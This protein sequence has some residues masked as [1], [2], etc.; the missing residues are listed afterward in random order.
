MKKIII[1]TTLLCI[2][3][4]SCT[5]NDAKRFI[6]K[7]NCNKIVTDNN[8]IDINSFSSNLNTDWKITA[9]FKDDG[10]YIIDSIVNGKSGKDYPQ[11]GSYSVVDES[12]IM[13]EEEAT[14]IILNNTMI[15][16]F[17]SGKV[18]HY[19]KKVE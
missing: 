4:C 6:G 2:V 15:I 13:L 5:N 12:N 8:E 19:Y 10:T 18:K 7:W 11:K 1:I 16:T 3:F 17:D 9:E 14:A